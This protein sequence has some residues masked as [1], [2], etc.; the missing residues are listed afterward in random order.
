MLSF[1]DKNNY[2]LLFQVNYY[3]GTTYFALVYQ[4]SLNH[5]D[6]IK[7]IIDVT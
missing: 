7:Y 3:H 1:S 4:I 5:F 6:E 2:L